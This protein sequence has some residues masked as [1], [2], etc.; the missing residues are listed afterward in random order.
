MPTMSAS[1]RTFS[2]GSSSIVLRIFFTLSGVVTSFD[3][4]LRCSSWQLVRPRLNSATQC[5]TA[6]KEGTDSPHTVEP[7]LEKLVEGEEKWEAPDHFQVVLPQYWDETELNH[8][9]TCMVLTATVNDRRHLALCH[10]EFRVSRS[11][12]CRSG[13]KQIPFEGSLPHPI[14]MLEIVFF[15]PSLKSVDAETLQTALARLRSD[16]IRSLEFV[17]K[18]K[19]STSSACPASLT[20]DIYCIGVSVRQLGS[21]GENG[22]VELY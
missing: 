16:H 10:D 4:L 21:E 17:D 15:N 11:G 8:S 13:L 19:T 2:Q 18:E 12:L 6:V 3:Q 14:G 1:S 7:P 22:S 5:F 9:V 20:H